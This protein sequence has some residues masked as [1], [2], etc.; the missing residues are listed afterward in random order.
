MV[1]A[2][3]LVDTRGRVSLIGIRNYRTESSVVEFDGEAPS[4]ME[5]ARA[6]RF[7]IDGGGRGSRPRRRCA[8]H[9]R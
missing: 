8:V 9:S 6:R 5:P 7:D 1:D 4:R 3:V 2:S